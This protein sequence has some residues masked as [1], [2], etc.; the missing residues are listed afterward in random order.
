MGQQQLLLLILGVII[1][2][3]AIA[4]GINLFSGGS[5]T[6]NRDEIIHHLNTIVSNAYA[7]ASKPV[8]LGGGDGSFGDYTI[9]QKLAVSDVG[10]YSIYL[11]RRG[12]K[13]SGKRH[14][15]MLILV[16]TSVLGYGTVKMTLDDSLNVR[17]FEYTG[18]FQ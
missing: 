5:V 8:S 2:G 17:L 10:T 3:I 11:K 7:F 13:G 16:G 6:S 1:V 14:K 9:P 15:G 18:D 4:V 12:N